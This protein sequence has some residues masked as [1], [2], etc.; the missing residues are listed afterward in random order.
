[1][2]TEQERAKKQKGRDH[3]RGASGQGC[4]KGDIWVETER[5]E[6]TTLHVRD[7]SPGRWH[8]KHWDLEAV[9]AYPANGA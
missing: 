9:P 2:N 6:G 5:V 4:G 7:S 1:M 3:I 8:S